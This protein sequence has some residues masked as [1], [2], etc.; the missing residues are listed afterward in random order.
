M[1]A[2]D[3]LPV[4]RIVEDRLV[5][6]SVTSYLGV[7]NSIADEASDTPTL[8]LGHLGFPSSLQLTQRESV[9]RAGDDVLLEHQRWP[10]LLWVLDVGQ[11]AS[12]LAASAAGRI[13]R[14]SR[15]GHLVVL[16]VSTGKGPHTNS[17]ASLVREC[18]GLYRAVAVATGTACTVLR[19]ESGNTG[20]IQVG[21]DSELVALLTRINKI[22]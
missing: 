3:S 1:V 16:L 5:C 6:R 7:D 15:S 19:L 10:L 9:A 12:R 13:L 21:P 4:V 14:M 17:Q 22:S 2:G 18:E 11:S 8:I 20:L